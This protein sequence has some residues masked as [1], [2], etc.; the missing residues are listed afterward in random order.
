MDDEINENNYLPNNFMFIF[1]ILAKNALACQLESRIQQFWIDKF[2]D[3]NYFD[4]ISSDYWK[5]IDKDK[6]IK[7]VYLHKSEEGKS[8]NLK[9]SENAT[10]I[11]SI[12]ASKGN[13]C[14]VVFLLGL[15]EMTLKKFS[16]D[17]KNIKYESL[18]HVALTRQK[19]S[20]Y[21]GIE[22]NNDDIYNRFRKYSDEIIK[23]KYSI[24][25]LYS[26][27]K[28]I[29]FSKII[30]FGLVN[31]FKDINDKIIIPNNY[32]NLIPINNEQKD[33][34]EWGHHII[35]YSVMIYYFLYNVINNEKKENMTSNS[36]RDQ[37]IQILKK[38]TDMSVFC[39]FYEKYY[40]VI[41][42]VGSKIE[43]K[44]GEIPIL[45]YKLSDKSNY[46]K[47]K[48]ILEKYIKNIQKKIIL[49]FEENL[50]PSLCPLEAVILQYMIEIVDS[51]KYSNITINDVYL[52][53]Y[54]YDECSNSISDE[55]IN[56]YKCC[57]EN[58]NN[59]NSNENDYKDIR[60]SITNHYNNTEKIREIYI[61]Y[62]KHIDNNYKDV[63][64]YSINKK[65]IVKEKNDN[66]DFI[67]N[68]QQVIIPYSD[69]Y[70][71]NFIIIPQFNKLNFY[72][73]IFEGIINDFIFS[74]YSNDDKF[75]NKKIITCIITLDSLEPIFIEFDKTQ[76]KDC[77]KNILNDYLF[78]EFIEKHNDI[79]NFVE[80]HKS[81]NKN[82]NE[83]YEDIITY[84]K[85]PKYILNYFSSIVDEIDENNYGENI[86]NNNDIIADILKKVYDKNIFLKNLEKKLRIAIN[87][88]LNV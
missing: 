65:I 57:C 38:R 76:Y 46:H 56:Y 73:K 15:T 41:N 5:N 87:K 52:V 53:M 85:F 18:L 36:E 10:K 34:I 23:S 35:R 1:P 49:T 42:T 82:F 71:I 24:P 67:I 43:N 79:F 45:E 6:F 7:Y 28:N 37:Y 69:N 13:G 72:E 74:F 29:K 40:D 22:K 32:M 50:M 80:Y 44:L 78:K 81:K 8:I 27:N 84:D 55:H 75:L 68:N 66:T 61:N 25:E 83:I 4:K 30:D 33:I 11:L 12:H 2:N 14:E 3:K 16:I 39:Y 62:K 17:N 77:I 47:Y 64:K 20:L 19:I 31:N 88:Y 48:N 21:V 54:Y 63:Y 60:N 70:V 59:K 9:E 58:K 51:G 86:E 26:I